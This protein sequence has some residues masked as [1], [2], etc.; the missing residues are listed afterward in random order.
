MLIF[1]HLRILMGHF[2]GFYFF[3]NEEEVQN[4][5]VYKT[6]DVFKQLADIRLF[7]MFTGTLN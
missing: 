1:S 5:Q 3:F 7:M 4:G 2:R 6:C